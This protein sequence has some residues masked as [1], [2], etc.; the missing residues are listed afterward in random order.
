MWD[1]TSDGADDEDQRCHRSL[2]CWSA[3]SITRI[4]YFAEDDQQSLFIGQHHNPVF[5]VA[6]DDQL[7]LF[8]LGQHH[9]YPV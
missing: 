1:I 5:C 6:D 7:S 2:S 8:L 4:Q 9:Q 3:I